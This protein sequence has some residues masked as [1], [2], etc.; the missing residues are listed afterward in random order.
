MA[1]E[2]SCSSDFESDKEHVSEDEVDVEGHSELDAD[3][4]DA[5]VTPSGTG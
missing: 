2:S 3:E 5:G 1:E 4:L